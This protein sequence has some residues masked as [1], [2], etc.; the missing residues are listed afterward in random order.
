MGRPKKYATSA[1]R[2]A[3][4]RERKETQDGDLRTL[5]YDLERAVWEAS[6]RGDPLALACRSSSLPTMLE[7]LQI[8]FEA[9]S[10]PD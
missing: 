7:R 6:Y 2:Q 1:D 5:L 9:R 4:H 8:A 3:A 10:K